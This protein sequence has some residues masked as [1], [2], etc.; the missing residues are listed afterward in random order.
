MSY[1][2]IGH[3][4]FLPS[5]VYKN[6]PLYNRPQY[7]PNLKRIVHAYPELPPLI[8]II[9]SHNA[10]LHYQSNELKL[11]TEKCFLM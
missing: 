5:G 8:V 9:F 4:N 6:N 2:K 11:M 3:I 7:F 1:Q 10:S